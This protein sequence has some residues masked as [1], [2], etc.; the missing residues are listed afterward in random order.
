MTI[1]LPIVEELRSLTDEAVAG[2]DET[3]AFL[4]ERWS[5]LDQKATEIGQ[6]LADTETAIDK[7]LK[8]TAEVEAYTKEHFPPVTAHDVWLREVHPEKF[9]S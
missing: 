6:A 9:R 4:Y 1:T 8:M 5:T 7:N 3:H 2:L